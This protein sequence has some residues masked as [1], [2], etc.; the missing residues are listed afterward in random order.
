MVDRRSLAVALSLTVGALG[1]AITDSPFVPEE[2]DCH[3]AL[4]EYWGTYGET[5]ITLFV[6]YLFALVYAFGGVGVAADVFMGSIEAITAVTK[7]VTL[8]KGEQTR[9]IDIE[10]WNKTVSNLSLMALGSSAPE[11]LLAIVEIVGRDFTAGDLGPGTIVGSA[12]FN[13]LI[14]IAICVSIDEIKKVE[15]IIVLYITA[16]ASVFAYLWLYIIVEVWT[17]NLCTIEEAV[18]TCAFFPV[19]LLI[20][21]CADKGWFDVDVCT[22]QVKKARGSLGGM[23]AEKTATQLALEHLVSVGNVSVNANGTSEW[24]RE[25]RR[26]IRRVGKENPSYSQ[27]EVY[28]RAFEQ[29]RQHPHSPVLSTYVAGEDTNGPQDTDGRPIKM[30]LDTGENTASDVG[31]GAPTA[32]VG[33]LEGSYDCSEAVGK[34]KLTVERKGN[35]QL[36]LK[37]QIVTKDVTA[38]E[39]KHYTICAGKTVEFVPGQNASIILIDIFEDDEY[40]PNHHFCIGLAPATEAEGGKITWTHRSVKIRILESYKFKGTCDMVIKTF[41]S[42]FA[43]IVSD[44]PA[45]NAYVEQVRTSLRF[46]DDDNDEDEDDENPDT[47]NVFLEEGKGGDGGDDSSDDGDDLHSF[48]DW[49]FYFY[50]VL[51]K[52]FIALL[53]PPVSVA[54]GWA[55]FIGS[56]CWIAFYTALCADLASQMG[57][58][59]GLKDSVTAITFV[60]LGTSVPDTFASKIAAEQDPNADPAIGNVTGSNAVNVF[61]GIGLSWLLGSVY[62]VVNNDAD[63]LAIPKSA[64]GFSVLVFSIMS[65]VWFAVLTVR[66]YLIGGELGGSGPAQWGTILLF[67]VMWIVFIVL[68]SLVEYGHIDSI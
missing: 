58:T 31:P 6:A 11:I 5:S 41:T 47:A 8:G 43:A 61:L 65:V 14:I 21:Y 42:F 29:V 18:I 46:E 27:D 35:M 39:S 55:T 4:F 33:F 64:L 51:P 37:L 38:K 34:L 16:G 40:E 54:S 24:N 9:T 3:G 12:A 48:M 17:P 25:L 56:L 44:E 45:E 66:R 30:A 2:E 62:Q 15:Q 63:G 19:L 52:F 7:P 10:V 57:C 1:Q 22:H 59:I 49:F 28:V 26:A 60:A 50:G 36:P 67:V 53:C 32:K 68:V 20:A 13:M 23:L